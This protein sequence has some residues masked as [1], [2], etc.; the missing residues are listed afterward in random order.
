MSGSDDALFSLDPDESRRAQ[1][2]RG[3]K[4][5]VVQI[6]AM[7]VIGFAMMTVAAFLYDLNLPEFPGAGFLT[8]LGI[9]LATA[10]PRSQPCE[11][12]TTGWAVST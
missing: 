5:N 10:W 12:S 1:Y 2:R 4:L 8:L 11:C 3:Y 6:P 9:N 7:R